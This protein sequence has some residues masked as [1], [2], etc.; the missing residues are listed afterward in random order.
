VRAEYNW[1]DCRNGWLTTAD[2]LVNVSRWTAVNDSTRLL[3]HVV[4]GADSAD[5]DEANGW[6]LFADSPLVDA[7][8]P[9]ALWSDG[10]DGSR[11][12]IGWTGGPLALVNEYTGLE[13]SGP[14]PRPEILPTAFRLSPPYPNPFN[15]ISWL[16]VELDRPGMLD[17]RVH[18]LL[19]R[20][21]AVL[22]R[23]RLE[24]GTYRLRVDGSAWASGMY[25]VQARMG[26]EQQSQR[27]ILV[28]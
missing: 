20:Q 23:D 11:N 7:G 27:L 15:P 2:G 26:D 17:V 18:D 25:V 28:K 13:G 9:G 14:R 16:D 21:V 22:A 3:S 12:D 1:Y 24:P 4:A 10:F 19:G 8:D 6:R 5:V